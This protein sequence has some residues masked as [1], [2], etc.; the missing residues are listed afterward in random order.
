MRLAKQ[1]VGGGWD[2]D[3]GSEGSKCTDGSSSSYDSENGESESE[4]SEVGELI[5]VST[6]IQ[7]DTTL[8]PFKP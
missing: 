1:H 8:N 5:R 3:E 4:F 6:C 2:E 7:S